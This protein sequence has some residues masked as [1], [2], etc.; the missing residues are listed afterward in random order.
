MG[1]DEDNQNVIKYK[2]TG[3]KIAIMEV[4]LTL[5]PKDCKICKSTYAAK[6]GQVREVRCLRCGIAACPNCV[7]KEDN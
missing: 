7:R 2:V 4:L 1:V 5:M 3:M 6:P